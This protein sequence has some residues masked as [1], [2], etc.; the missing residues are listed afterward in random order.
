MEEHHV[1]GLTGVSAAVEPVVAAHPGRLY[2][3]SSRVSCV[4]GIGSAVG[5]S[6]P[7]GPSGRSSCLATIIGRRTRPGGRA[8][9]PEMSDDVVTVIACPTAIADKHCA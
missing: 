4:R 1:V 5:T 3:S 2:F 8:V 9:M 7:V 6:A